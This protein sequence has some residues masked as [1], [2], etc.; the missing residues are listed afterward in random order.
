[1]NNLLPEL[2]QPCITAG[3][4]KMIEDE[5]LDRLGPVMADA[6]T[7]VEFTAARLWDVPNPLAVEVLLNSRR[8]NQVRQL[9]LTIT[10]DRR[11]YIRKR[12][13]GNEASFVS[14]GPAPLSY[15]NLLMKL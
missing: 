10:S 11:I 6:I 4:M 8:G 7:G 1:M 15:L 2:T 5:E 14:R 9:V 12:E 13:D 3:P